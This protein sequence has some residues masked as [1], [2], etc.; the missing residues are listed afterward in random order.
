L[1]SAT[2]AALI[3]E[4]PHRVELTSANAVAQ[5]V[6]LSGAALD[7]SVVAAFERLKD[8]LNNFRQSA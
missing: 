4:R 2:Y 8:T 7:P 6:G 1:K 5:I 3:S